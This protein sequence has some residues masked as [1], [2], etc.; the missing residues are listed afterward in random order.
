[1][2]E[3]AGRGKNSVEVEARLAVVKWGVGDDGSIWKKRE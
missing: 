3:A 1:M 2:L